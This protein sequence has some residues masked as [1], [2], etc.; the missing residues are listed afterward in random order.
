MIIFFIQRKS[1]DEETKTKFESYLN[2]FWVALG[3][4][5]KLQAFIPYDAK[6]VT[7]NRHAIYTMRP[8]REKINSDL[9]IR[10]FWKVTRADT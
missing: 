2:S 6:T 10:P 9:Y 5:P 8:H 4:T 3:F 7:H 1:G